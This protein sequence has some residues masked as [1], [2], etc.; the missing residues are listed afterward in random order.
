MAV[1]FDPF[2]LDQRFEPEPVRCA[3]SPV[4]LVEDDDLPPPQKPAWL[5]I[6]VWLLMAVMA[7]SSILTQIGIG[8]PPSP[9]DIE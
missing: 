4:H 5:R 7:M 8:H 9:P 6:M 2:R 3:L 1:S